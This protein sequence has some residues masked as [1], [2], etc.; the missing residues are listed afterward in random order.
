MKKG[1][2]LSLNLLQRSPRRLQTISYFSSGQHT[3]KSNTEGGSHVNTIR[4]QFTLQATGFND[5]HY[6]SNDEALAIFQARGNWTKNDVIIDSGCGPGI[7][8]RYMARHVRKVVGVD[9]TTEM[10][11]VAREKAK[12]DSS[13]N[14]KLSYV[15][16]NMYELPFD[17]CYF[18]GSLTRYTFHHLENPKKA[19]QEMI[20]VTKKGGRIVVVDATPEAAK[21]NKYNDFEILRDPSHTKA[22]TQQQ[23]LDLGKDFVNGNIVSQPTFSSLRL[24]LDAQDLIDKAFPTQCTRDDLMNILRRDVGSNAL[25]FAVFYNK[26]TN[27]LEMSFPKTCVVWTKL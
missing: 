5:F 14:E 6:H 12:E 3:E 1:A 9:I 18:D 24:K 26:S 13:I 20:R 21:Q 10:L 23:L 25:D 15:E 11:R 4:E 22:L 19:L 17:D 2:L 27:K 8:S 16:G 7:V